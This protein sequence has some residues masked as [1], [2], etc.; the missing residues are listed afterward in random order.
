[1]K[2]RLAAKLQEVKAELR[3]PMPGTNPMFLKQQK[4]P[5]EPDVRF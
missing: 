5:C 4:D 3:K 1:M 2:R